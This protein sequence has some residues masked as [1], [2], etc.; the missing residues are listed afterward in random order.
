M[1]FFLAVLLVLWYLV[2]KQNHS[3]RIDNE[4][5]EEIIES[6]KLELRTETDYNLALHSIMKAYENELGFTKANEVFEK[7]SD[8]KML[9]DIENNLKPKE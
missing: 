7:I 9:E 1:G 3:L 4:R 8:D 2:M 5:L 6:Y